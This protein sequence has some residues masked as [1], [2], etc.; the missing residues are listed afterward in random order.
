MAVVLYLMFY[1]VATIG[2]LIV[3]DFRKRY[4]CA[5]LP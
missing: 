5:L 3:G 1:T 4:W 2:L